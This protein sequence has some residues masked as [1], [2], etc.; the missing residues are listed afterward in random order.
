MKIELCLIEYVWNMY[1]SGVILPFQQSPSL[2]HNCILQPI[3]LHLSNHWR[4]P[5]YWNVPHSKFINCEIFMSH[6][7]NDKVQL[8]HTDFF[9][10]LYL[11]LNTDTLYLNQ[12]TETNL[13]AHELIW[14]VFLLLNTAT[15]YSYRKTATKSCAVESGAVV[16]YSGR[17]DVG[18][19]AHQLS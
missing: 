12:K 14:L 6:Q 5:A 18:S 10:L 4:R 3:F 19:K 9:L 7:T 8:N 1:I 13:N 17:A 16:A 2:H 15:F 11:F